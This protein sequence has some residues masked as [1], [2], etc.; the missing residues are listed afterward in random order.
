MSLNCLSQKW[1]PVHLRARR[2]EWEKCSRDDHAIVFGIFLFPA[3]MGA[4][5]LA[6]GAL[7]SPDHFFLPLPVYFH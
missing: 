1:G 2:S 6:H 7:L 4:L 5:M 3:V